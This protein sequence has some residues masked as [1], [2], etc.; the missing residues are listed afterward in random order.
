MQGQQRIAQQMEQAHNGTG[1]GN[2]PLHSLG[3]S[4]M[5]LEYDAQNYSR[6]LEAEGERLFTPTGAGKVSI[7]VLIARRESSGTDDSKQ[8]N[9]NRYEKNQNE[10]QIQNIL[11][12]VTKS[13]CLI[14]N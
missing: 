4:L 1:N 9:S 13:S 2:Q 10:T 3:N 14:Y 11:A 7:D 12:Q 5:E 8:K 6:R